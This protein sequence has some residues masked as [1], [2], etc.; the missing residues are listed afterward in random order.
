MVILLILLNLNDSENNLNQAS[1]SVVTPITEKW[2][3]MGILNYNISQNHPQTYLLGLQYDSCCW[4][5]RLAGGRT[6][7]AIDQ[8][9]RSQFSEAVYVQFELKG[10]ANIDP[11]NLGLFLAGQ[12]P[13]YR[14]PFVQNRTFI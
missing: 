5:F 10:L 14:D 2:S 3:A 8:A 12:I 13:G 6:F 7:T 9:G 1:V 11:Q 4:A